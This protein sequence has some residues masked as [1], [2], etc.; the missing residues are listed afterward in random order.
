MLFLL[1]FPLSSPPTLLPLL[2]LKFM[3]SFSLVVIVRYT[4]VYTLNNGD[5]DNFIILK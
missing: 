2:S 3:V 4:H 5:A 1:L